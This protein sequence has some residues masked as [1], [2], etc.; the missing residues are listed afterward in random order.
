MRQKFGQNFLTNQKI[1][2]NIVDS[3]NIKATDFV[4]EIGPGKGV[5]TEKISQLAKKVIA[6]E[7][8]SALIAPL[9]SKFSKYPQVEVIELN[10]LD[11]IIPQNEPI[12]FISNLPYCVATAIIAKILPLSNWQSAV[13]MVQK[14]VGERIAANSGTSDFGYFSVFC[15]YYANIEKLFVVKPES[16]SPAPQVNS[17][18]VR[19][20][21]KNAKKA[22]SGFFTF[23]KGAFSQKR[24]TILNSLSNSLKIEKNELLPKLILA[25]ISPTDRPEKL[26]L[27]SYQKLFSLLK[28]NNKKH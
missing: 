28:N 1:A 8:D 13:F 14:E 15:S 17:I 24:K 9:K 3:L 7:I 2:Q 21:N 11:F 27:T 23:V 26:S 19:L 20:T 4:I 10:F 6:V 5:L 16:F 22:E 18:V 12:K 25:E